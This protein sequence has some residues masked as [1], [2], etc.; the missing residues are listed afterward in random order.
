MRRRIVPIAVLLGLVAAA[1]AP[2]RAQPTECAVL[3]AS[4][5]VDGDVDLR[6]CE[7]AGAT[8]YTVVRDLLE[9]GAWDACGTWDVAGTPPLPPFTDPRPVEWPMLWAVQAEDA[10]GTG[11]HSTVAW[12]LEWD[13]T[14]VPGADPTRFLI[15]MP[16]IGGPRSSAEFLVRIYQ[17]TGTGTATV[18]REDPATGV[19]ATH[20]IGE[21]AEGPELSGEQF[22]IG[23]GEI[24]LLEIDQDFTPATFLAVGSQN[25]TQPP[26][27]LAW[28]DPDDN[29]HFVTMPPDVAWADSEEALLQLFA[30]NGCAELGLAY[31]D[32]DPASPTFNQYVFQTVRG[33]PFGDPCD[34]IITGTRFD[35]LPGVGHQI[36]MLAAPP[37][38]SILFDPPVHEC[39]DGTC[40]DGLDCD[41]DTWRDTRDNCIGTPNPTQADMDG[42]GVGDVCDDDVDGDGS[43]SADDCDDADPLNFPGNPE[44]C[45]DGQDND[46]DTLADWDDPDC[47]VPDRDGDTVPD[48]DDNCP[49]DWN[50]GQGDTDGDLI[51]DACDTCTDTDGDGFGNPGFPVNTCP[52]DNCPHLHNDGQEDAD[53]DGVGDAC[54]PC[55]DTD[56]DGYGNPG[57]PASTCPED[58]CPSLSNPGQDNTDGD[59]F[60]DVCDF[61]TDTDGDGFGNPGFPLNTCDEDNC[62]ARPN[63]GQEDVDG[64][65]VGDVCD[66][67]ETQAVIR[68][69]SRDRIEW[70]SVLGVISYNTFR[71][72]IPRSG[73]MGS[74][75]P[76]YAAY[77]HACFEA[78]DAQGNG[79]RVTEDPTVPSGNLLYYL[80]GVV[81]IYGEGN[82]GDATIDLDPATPGDQTDRPP[83]DPP[84][85]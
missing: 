47:P 41:G 24:F 58:N 1:P 78:G 13:L 34:P 75:G 63:P 5:N 17:E 54:D 4:E 55:T 59:A 57:F 74:R 31:W 53:G 25:P 30:D 82:T 14:P 7:I 43:A 32:G 85:P 71:G 29:R 8:S 62:P 61:C 48:F 40:L 26:L 44:V 3:E 19:R 35:L 64:D 9:P 79:L 76:G 80:V 84:C 11:P 2:L 33:D 69:E 81:S 10:V 12:A 56:G 28:S 42:D 52:D 15:G 36:F 16:D 68:F 66:P 39:N 22:A 49:D 23:P 77:D 51:G 70:D 73:G 65:G 72:T 37:G 6:W 67:D 50:P 38:N 21:G 45:E 27:V 60:G 83:G 20:S 46:C 18:H